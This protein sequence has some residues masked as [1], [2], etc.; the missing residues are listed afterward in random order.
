MQLPSSRSSLRFSSVLASTEVSLAANLFV[1]DAHGTLKECGNSYSAVRACDRD[2]SSAAS[3]FLKNWKWAVFVAALVSALWAL[4]AWIRL[5]EWRGKDRR[6]WSNWALLAVGAALILVEAGGGGWY[7]SEV[8]R[9]ARSIGSSVC[10]E[11]ASQ[12]TWVSSS[13]LPGS[14]SR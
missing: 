13:G 14:A 6:T 2:M 1:D 8:W 10:L 9:A 7:L 12:T 3:F 4:L 5:D 11:R